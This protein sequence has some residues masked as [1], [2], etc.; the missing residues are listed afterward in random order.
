MS[1]EMFQKLSPNSVY[2]GPMA[3]QRPSAN[4]VTLTWFSKSQMLF[5]MANMQD[6]FRSL[7]EEIYEI[8]YTEAPGE[9]E[10]KD[11]TTGQTWPYFQGHEGHSKWFLLNMWR[12]IWLILTTFGTQKQQGKTKD[13]LNFESCLIP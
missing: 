3:R 9:G 5:K 6:G 10:Y 8:L 12:I 4:L 2:R 11:R 13:L 1:E 7:S